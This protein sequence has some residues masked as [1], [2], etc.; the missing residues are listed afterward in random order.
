MYSF[1][2]LLEKFKTWIDFFRSYF[3]PAD[4]KGT[5]EI[6]LT[7]GKVAVIDY[8]D[9]GL[10]SKYKW[11]AQKA[12]TS[13]WYA[14]TTYREGGKQKSLYMQR[15]LMQPKDDQIVDFVDGNGLNLRRSNMRTCTVSQDQVNRGLPKNNKSGF[16][17]V[18]A[19]PNKNGKW[20]AFIFVEGR[21]IR[22]GSFFSAQGAAIE[23]DKA[24]KAHFGEFA[25]LNFPTLKKTA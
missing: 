14:I 4:G 16:K 15:L 1:K 25:W 9:F 23:R 18:S 10:V 12:P 13:P 21:S 7:R 20:D 8:E 5:K 11:C 6:F 22:L 19:S 2:N 3:V 24:A 17:G